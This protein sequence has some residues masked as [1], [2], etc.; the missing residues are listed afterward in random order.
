MLVDNLLP[1]IFSP[2]DR[3]GQGDSKGGVASWKLSPKIFCGSRGDLTAT[4]DAKDE[5]VVVGVQC[6]H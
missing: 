5:S 6:D 1:E 2:T 3:S 4:E